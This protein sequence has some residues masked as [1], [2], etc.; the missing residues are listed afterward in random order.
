MT[1]KQRFRNGTFRLELRERDHGPPHVHLVGGEFDVLV[2]LGSLK[3]TGRWPRG[4]R[5]E[6]LE[7]IT[8]HHDELMEE[9]QR[10]HP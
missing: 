2:E 1:T 9:W 8:Q 3:C 6:V 10:W 4:L 5:A 7:W